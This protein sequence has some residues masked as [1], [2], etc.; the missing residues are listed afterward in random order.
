[1][2]MMVARIFLDTNILLR[3]TIQQFP[4]YQEIQEFVA[5]YIT[6]DSELWISRQV[7]REY[8]VQAMRPQSFMNPMSASQSVQ[9]VQSMQHI[10]QIA[11]ETGTTT[12]ELLKLIQS[13]SVGGKQIHD[14]NIVATMLANDIDILMTLNTKYFQRF[15]DKITLISP[16]E[17]DN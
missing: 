14:T 3:S 17:M 11:D 6:G 10:F 13:Y 1:M 12:R 16:L 9:Q 7:I 2:V 5:D 4:H 8:L 15:A